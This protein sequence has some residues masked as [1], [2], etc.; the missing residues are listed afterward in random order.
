MV[1]PVTDSELVL[2]KNKNVLLLAKVTTT[3]A[4]EPKPAGTL[5][6]EDSSGQLLQTIAMTAPTGAIPTTV[7][8]SPSFATAYS[9]TIPAALINSGVVLKASLANGQPAT[10]VTPRVGAENVITLMA[11]PVKIQSTTV[12]MPTGMAAYFQP[13]VPVGKVTE[14]IHATFTSTAVPTFPADESEWSTAMGKILGEMAALRTSESGSNRTYYYGFLPKT[15]YGQV[16]LGYVPGNAAVGVGKFANNN[17]GVALDTM[18]HELG[19]NLSLSH[20]PCGLTGGDPQYPYAGGTLGGSGRYIWGYNLSTATFIDATDTSKH[21]AMSYCS[22]NSFSDYSYRKMQKH[23]TPAD[24]LYV[25]EAKAAELPQELLLI[26]GQLDASGV[27]VNPLKAFQGLLQAP[28]PGPYTLRIV[29]TSGTVQY[30]FATD[31][32]DHRS[33]LALFSFSVPNPGQ[34][35]SVSIL[36]GDQV[37]YNSQAVAKSGIYTKS[38]PQTQAVEQGGVLTVQWDAQTYPYLMVTHVGDKR[39]TLIV[40][41]KGG[42]LQLPIQGVPA[43]GRFELSFSDGLNAM[44]V[45]QKR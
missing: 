20:A 5:R 19:H 17:M 36:R 32:L 34:V 37:L 31:T 45:E 33:D 1:Y 23:L 6:V 25:N 13:K 8:I 10:S 30:P 29:T 9:A 24:A 27:K 3:N 42:K 28:A 14:Q 15:T 26:S 18:V 38:A 39:S 16:G 21:D 12:D 11:V 22:G 4:S 40:D 44:R 2:V 43:G 7:P 41:A 35:L